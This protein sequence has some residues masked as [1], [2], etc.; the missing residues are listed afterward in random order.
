MRLAWTDG[1]RLRIAAD[2]TAN[3]E[4]LRT[5]LLDPLERWFRAPA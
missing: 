1:V 3:V 4:Q 5:P 2:P